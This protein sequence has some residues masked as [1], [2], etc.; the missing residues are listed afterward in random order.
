M[1][2]SERVVVTGAS[3]FLGE[4]ITRALARE[5]TPVVGTY[6]GRPIDVPGAATVSVDL[7]KSG[8]AEAIL[9]EFR[10]NV[11]IH[12]AAQ[13]NVAEAE[14]NPTEAEQDIVDATRNLV[15]A[16][17]GIDPSIHLVHV[18][19]DQVYDGVPREPARPYQASDPARPLSVYG[20]L[21]W[22]A[23]RVL[24]PLASHTVVRT[25][26]IM[27]PKGT[28]RGSF[29]EWLVQGLE[30]GKTL[31]LF[32]DEI[33]T[34]IDVEDLAFALRTLGRQRTNGMFL[35]GGPDR[36]SRFEM[37][38]RVA[39]VGGFSAGVI[40]PARLAE[41]PTPAPRPADLTLDSTPL[42]REVAHQPRSFDES[43]AR[44]LATRERST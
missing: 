19:T 18:S 6:R 23:E 3:G 15:D 44:A 4:V 41:S 9:R 7:A 39:K 17:Q 10:P 27:G 25:A 36:L 26:L 28:H 31:P 24:S 5:G 1:T 34:P 40:L 8:S 16:I 14:R 38:Q 20:R 35:A 33:R 42:W 11:I 21:K 37:G 32:V 30:Q 22:E 2:S 29:L 13:T 43:L 12:T